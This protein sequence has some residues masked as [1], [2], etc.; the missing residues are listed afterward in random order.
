[1]IP[2]YYRADTQPARSHVHNLPLIT[3]NS[4]LG[5]ARFRSSYQQLTI[6]LR[7]RTCSNSDLSSVNMTKLSCTYLSNTSLPMI[8]DASTAAVYSYKCPPSPKSALPTVSI[9]THLPGEDNHLPTASPNF[10]GRDK[11]ARLPTLGERGDVSSPKLSCQALT[12]ATP[13][14]YLCVNHSAL[15]SHTTWRNDN[16]YGSTALPP[17]RFYDSTNLPNLFKATQR[18]TTATVFS[19]TSTPPSADTTSHTMP[20]HANPAFGKIWSAYRLASS[21]TLPFPRRFRRTEHARTPTISYPAPPLM[22]L[23]PSS[24]L[25]PGQTTNTTRHHGKLPYYPPR[26]HRRCLTSSKPLTNRAQL[27]SIAVMEVR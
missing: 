18:Q 14:T 2:I 23:T 12:T 6:H 27:S 15:G 8:Y 7:S 20:S 24:Y 19:R 21:P 4:P 17:Q 13:R 11:H 3:W 1:M 26:S 22:N 16:G 10:C 5:F 9:S 25:P